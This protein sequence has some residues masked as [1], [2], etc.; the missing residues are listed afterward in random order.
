MRLLG[1]LI[2]LLLGGVALCLGWMVCGVLMFITIIG[3]PWGKSCFVMARFA[4]WPFGYEAVSRKS[5]IGKDD[6]GT[7]LIGLIGNIVWFLLA[8]IWLCIGHIL[9]GLIFCITIIGIPFGIQHFK[10]AGL[11]LFPVGKTIVDR[12]VAAASRTS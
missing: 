12:H 3:I 8:G 7:G 11:A 4:L 10:L 6:I 5:L 1:N 2:W 9:N